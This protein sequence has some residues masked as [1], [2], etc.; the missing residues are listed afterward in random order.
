MTGAGRP[1]PSS[2]GAAVKSIVAQIGAGDLNG[3]LES[4]SGLVRRTIAEPLCTAR[5]FSSPVLDQLCALAGRAALAS[6]GSRDAG[7]EAPLED[8]VIFVASRLQAAGGHTRVM[9]DFLRVLPHASK[10]MLVTGLCG[11][12]D[13]EDAARRFGASG[14]RIEYAPRENSLGRLYWLQRRIMEMRGRDLYL[15]N[16]HEDSVAVA[17]MESAGR[18]QVHFYHHGDHHLCLGVHMANAK[19]I[20]IHAFGHHNCRH[21]LKVENNT[22]LPL[23]AEDL[24]ARPP[25]MPFRR[26]GVL[27]T[28]TAAGWNKLE[29][30]HSVRYTDVVPAL[31]AAT[32]GRH[33]HIGKLTPLG[34]WR[35]RRGLRRRGVPPSAFAYIPWVPSVWRA[36]HEYGVDLYVSSFPVTGGRTMVEVMGAGIPVAVHDHPTSRFLGG[37]DMAYKGAYIWREPNDLLAVC[38]E[39]TH[40]QL[41]QHSEKARLHYSRFHA[42]ELLRG[43]LVEGKECPVPPLQA[44]LHE[45]DGLQLA[46]EIGRHS[47]LLAWLLKGLRRGHLRVRAW[48]S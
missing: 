43:A 17:A 44:Q 25:G 6:S 24:G 15:F 48:L 19:H 30:P 4:V 23:T 41:R 35:I 11:R 1:V 3:A 28:C 45:V 39:A 47:T 9:E 27:T 20:D 5:V 40:A 12:S 32:G 21:A 7:R 22:Y 29:L 10:V 13:R 34:L 36:L 18:T 14:V 38:A 8:A 46:L 33:V 37:I 31:L 2:S 16:H 42:P 26:D